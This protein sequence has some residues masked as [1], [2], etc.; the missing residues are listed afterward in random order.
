MADTE[1]KQSV[2]TEVLLPIISAK[3]NLLKTIIETWFAKKG[4]SIWATI[5][6]FLVFPGLGGI[7]GTVAT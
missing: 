7:L 6:G 3:I 4:G 2:W 5:L 1:L